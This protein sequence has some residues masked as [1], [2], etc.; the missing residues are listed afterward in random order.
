MT[1]YATV[2]ELKSRIQITSTL[3]EAQEDLLSD[4]L[5][6]ASKN[7]DEVCNRPDG[8]QALTTATARYFVGNGK[9]YLR[10]HECVEVEE[11]AVKAS[12]TA[13]TYTVWNAPTSAMAGDG[14]WIPCT[15]LTCRPKFNSIPYTLLLVDINGDESYFLN[16]ETTPVIKITA[17][18]GPSVE[19]PTD[20]REACLMQAARWYKRFQASA[21]RS[22]GTADF[23]KIEYQRNLDSCVKQILVDGGW[24]I[25]L[26]GA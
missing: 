11:V 16:S 10:I 17:K 25:P 1:V 24:M 13:T 22:L 6:A 5:T 3:T 8:F 2:A 15:G 12:L 19:I 23:A 7:L 18:W 26:Y 9:V 4:L 21:G 20:I 14:D